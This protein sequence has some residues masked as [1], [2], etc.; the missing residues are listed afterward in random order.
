V[1]TLTATLEAAQKAMSSR[2]YVTAVLSDEEGLVSRFRFSRVYTGSEHAGPAACCVAGD[3]SLIRARI[4]TSSDTLYTQRVT[5]PGTGSTFSSW[6][7]HGTVGVGTTCALAK[8]GSNVY[9]FDV[10]LD[11]LRVRMKISTDN[12]ATYGSAST[13]KTEASSVTHVAADCNPDGDVLLLWTMGTDVRSSRYTGSWSAAASWGKSV[14]SITGIAATWRS[15]LQVVVTGTETTTTDA[16]VYTILYGDGF[17]LTA[18]T[19]GDLLA[20]DTAVAGSDVTFH[21]PSL[22]V[23]GS[24]YRLAFLEKYAG[25][26]ASRRLQLSWLDFTRTLAVDRWREPWPLEY[27]AGDDFGVAV[28]YGSADDVLWLSSPAGVWYAALEAVATLDVSADV[29]SV[30]V[31]IDEDNGRVR[32]EL[33]NADG[34]YTA[35]ASVSRGMQL[36]LTPGYVSTAGNESG[37]FGWFWV[38]AVELITGPRPRAVLH[39]RDGWWLLERWHARRQYSWAA[40]ATTLLEELAVVLARAG[41]SADS[42]D[43][44]TTL[45]TW[46]PAFTINPG[47]S[48]K[49]VVQ[50]ILAALPDAL[51]FVEGGSDIVNLDAG[52]G[53]DYAY[54]AGHAVVEGRYREVGPAVNRTRVVGASALAEAFDYDDIAAA[55]ERASAPIRDLNLTTDTLVEDRADFALRSAQIHARRDELEIFGVNCGQELYD[56]VAVTDAQAGLSAATRRVLGLSWRFETAGW[57]RYDMTLRLGA[58]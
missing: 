11:T 8:S 27:A 58:V 5:T 19:W 49:S 56:V 14:D 3:G 7:S 50:R 55:G 43:A 34:T 57:P 42:G 31:D 35:H 45:Q 54:G 33:G 20:V 1:K 37:A 38:E 23:A 39:A 25:S 41:V 44:S 29:V 40:G 53:T 48:G 52:D 16:K 51:R 30:Q 24:A 12:G 26:V 32:L 13:V 22:D 17:D 9:L 47:E 2:P 21:A 36:T 15:D 18:D 10:H 28:A 46:E 4:D 6:T